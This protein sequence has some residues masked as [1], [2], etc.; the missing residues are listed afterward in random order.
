MSMDKWNYRV[1]TYMF[2]YKKAIGKDSKLADHPDERLYKI[3][4]VYYKT[5]DGKV[6]PE[7]YGAGSQTDT[8]DGFESFKDLKRTSALI[9][10][11]YQKPILD[12]D[13]FPSEFE[14]DEDLG[15]DFRCPICKTV[16][17]YEY[18]RCPNNCKKK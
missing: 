11:A 2:S 17:D 3:V 9:Q 6:M 10:L 12:L 13:N 8:L 1:G 15:F 18:D 7:A 16:W 5:V 4:S 14:E